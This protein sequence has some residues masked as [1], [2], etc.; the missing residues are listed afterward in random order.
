MAV[1]AV[2]KSPIGLRRELNVHLH[3]CNAAWPKKLRGL[4]V[5]EVCVTSQATKTSIAMGT[6][7][8]ECRYRPTY[9]L[10]LIN[11]T[12]YSTMRLLIVFG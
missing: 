3:T 11:H 2:G 10:L 7:C 12:S 8:H 4:D 9:L 1:K 5:G 6:T